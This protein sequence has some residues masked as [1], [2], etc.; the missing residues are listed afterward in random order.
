[1]LG[2]IIAEDLYNRFPRLREGEL[3]RLRA[4][5]VNGRSLAAIARSI[6]LG[7]HIRLGSGELRSGGRN[8]DSILA[9]AM[10]AVTAAIYRDAGM[11]P[12]REC[13]LAWFRKRLESLNPGA[14]HK[15]AKTRLQEVLQARRKPLPVYSVVEVTGQAHDQRFVVACDVAL[16]RSPVTGTGRSRRAAEQEAASEALAFIE[17]KGPDK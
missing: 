17:L 2:Q 12:V 3:S 7:P 4:S 11:D 1:M 13:V 5:L 6:D 10:E 9:D 8:R 16:L 14:S 15:D